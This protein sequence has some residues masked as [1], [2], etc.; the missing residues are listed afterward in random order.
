MVSHRRRI[1]IEEKAK[2]VVAVWGTE[3]IQFFAMLA[4]LQLDNLK[5]RMNCTGLGIHSFQK[6]ATFLLSFPF[7]IKER[8]IL[9][10]LFHS[11]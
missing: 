6:N 4:I 7:F 9:C 5:N 3:F 11:L 2:V 1:K 8:G 10:V